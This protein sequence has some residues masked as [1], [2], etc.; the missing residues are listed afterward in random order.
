MEGEG[1]RRD[2]RVEKIQTDISEVDTF[3]GLDMTGA[4]EGKGD[5]EGDAPMPGLSC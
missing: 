4:G 3:D 2:A 5:F 1:W